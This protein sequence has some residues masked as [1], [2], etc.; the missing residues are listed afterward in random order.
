MKLIKKKKLKILLRN[1]ENI[2][3]TTH[4]VHVVIR[5]KSIIYDSDMSFC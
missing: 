5:S 2:N 1:D 3:I 4:D